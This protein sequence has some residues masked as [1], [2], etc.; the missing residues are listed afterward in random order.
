MDIVIV[1]S[2]ELQIKNIVSQI[3]ET[4]KNAE[5]ET[6]VDP[7]LAIKHL[8]THSC[9]ILFVFSRIKLLAITQ[10]I[11]TIRK[12]NHD[13]EIY[14]IAETDAFILDLKLAGADD[15][16]IESNSKEQVKKKLKNIFDG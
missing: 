10:F 5:I 13:I 16:I 9:D 8:S 3:I 6:F 12:S 15:V 11:Q 1:A 14:V 7:L 2:K 4:T